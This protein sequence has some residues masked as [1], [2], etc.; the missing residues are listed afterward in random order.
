M[1]RITIGMAL[2]AVTT[3]LGLPALAASASAA[4]ATAAGKAVAVNDTAGRTAPAATS[5]AATDVSTSARAGSRA[6]RTSGV[7]ASHLDGTC[8]HYYSD[9]T[10]DLC[11]WYFQNYSGSK[12]DFYYGDSNL[13]NNY[14]ITAG[15]GQ[16]AVVANNA[17][18][19]FNYDGIYTA[20]VCTGTSSSGSCG[21]ISPL[22]GGN[23]NTTYKNNVESF[24]W[25]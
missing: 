6:E 11:L 17:E 5:R 23:F 7:S 12:I 16:G 22:T 20:W 3:V 18:S 24:Y 2:V 8:N 14:F 9:N 19:D 1:R 25:A 4:P 15:S 13:F 21:F 10:G